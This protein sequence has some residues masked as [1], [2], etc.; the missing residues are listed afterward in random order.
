MNYID[1]SKFIKTKIIKRETS[2]FINDIINNKQILFDRIK[3]KSVLVIGGAGTIGSNYIKEILKFKPLKL[4]VVDYNEN[5]LTELTRTL[6]SKHNQY[7]PEVY[8][9]YPMDFG[10]SIFYKMLSKHGPFDIVAN[11][12]AYKHVRSEKDIFSIESMIDNNVFKAKIFLDF[13][14]KNKPKYFF[15]VSTDK[16]TNPVNVM[17][18]SKKIMEELIMSY[19]DKLNV[20][21]AR[22]ANV[23]FSNGSLLSGYIERIFK[24]Q[25]I[26]CPKDI[27]R[28]FVSPEESG[29][30]CML[31]CMLGSSGDI[32]F[33]KFSEDKLLSFNDIT[34]DFF[35]VLSREII[36]CKSEE[37]AKKLS[38]NLRDSD[39]YPVYFFKT[40]TSGEKI[41]EEFFSNKDN[42]DLDSFLS[43]GV[44]KNL[45]KYS[46]KKTELMLKALKE[47]MESDNCNKL[48][49]INVLGKFIPDFKHIETGINLD[50]RM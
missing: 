49:I 26:S 15:C 3:N 5:G 4:V 10:N 31:A 14:V 13:L 35:S 20:K 41:F 42:L 16:A 40:E 22:F 19:S 36:K 21:T 9:T 33:P 8:L 38:V 1:I 6:R 24:R 43:L 12:A 45:K 29:Q 27:K 11:F 37:E 28:F 18:A 7:I 46:I 50:Q 32:F 44:I 39:P 23:A 47:V 48:S 30:I 17:G 2:F 25:P 34:E